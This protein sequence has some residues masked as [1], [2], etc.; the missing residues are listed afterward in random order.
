LLKLTISELKD[1]SG[2]LSL[3]PI[4]KMPGLP[5]IIAFHPGDELRITT[6]LDDTGRLDIK[7]PTIKE[8][9]DN[10][11]GIDYGIFTNI[12]TAFNS[13]E[14]I[15]I[16]R[17]LKVISQKGKVLLSQELKSKEALGFYDFE[18]KAPDEANKIEFSEKIRLAI[19][20]S[21]RHLRDQ[22]NLLSCVFI[23]ADGNFLS[24][25]S[26]SY[27]YRGTLD[28]NTTSAY[29]SLLTKLSMIGDSYVDNGETSTIVCGMNWHAACR[30]YV[31]EIPRIP[32]SYTE[33]MELPD[34]DTVIL[35]SLTLGDVINKVSL[36]FEDPN[37]MLSTDS[38]ISVSDETTNFEVPIETQGTISKSRKT[39]VKAYSTIFKESDS[40]RIKLVFTDRAL[41][42]VNET[43]KTV[44]FF[45]L[46]YA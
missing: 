46:M 37:L 33:N 34:S 11:V 44:Y 38:V 29:T 27:W 17:D 30:R 1:I 43:T 42:Y 5:P 6:I 22:P 9:V 20:D 31:G 15:E 16:D 10:M 26:T 25:S 12:A 41:V 7:F 32:I 45:R 4:N 8:S 40:D 19:K 3:F 2:K 36:L 35:T 18:V 28:Y 14:T 13:N 21:S 24:I 23:D 39:D